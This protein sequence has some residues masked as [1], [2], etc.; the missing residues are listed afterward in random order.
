[1]KSEL[2]LHNSNVVCR[3]S[4]STEQVE[5]S[6]FKVS[7]TLNMSI[8]YNLFSSCLSLGQSGNSGLDNESGHVGH[9]SQATD[10]PGPCT[11]VKI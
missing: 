8:L 2:H 5:L 6:V 3:V 10:Q 1:M 4:L 7:L 11:S 9:F